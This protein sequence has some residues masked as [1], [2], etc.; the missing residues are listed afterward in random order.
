MNAYRHTVQYYETDRMGIVHH[1]NYIRWMEE[2]RVDYLA[3]LGWGLERLEA[4]GSVSPATYLD[5]KYKQT[6]TF[7]DVISIQVTL[8]QFT[9][10]RLRLHYVMTKEGGLWCLREIQSTVSR[11]SRAIFC[12]CAR[13]FRPLPRPWTSSWRPARRR[14][15]R[16]YR[17][18]RKIEKFSTAANPVQSR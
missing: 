9:G 16:G 11:T 13:H 7:P 3:Q 18:R 14:E 5:A 8:T 15:A 2:A 1:S 6:T 4:M 10:V 12:V 17:L